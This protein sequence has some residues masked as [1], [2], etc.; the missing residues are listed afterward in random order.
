MDR[1]RVPFSMTLWQYIHRNVWLPLLDVLFPP[2]CLHC[3]TSLYAAPGLPLCASC[4]NELTLIAPQWVHKH[5]LE[6][7]ENRAIDQ[8]V[9]ALEFNAV[10]QTLIHHLKY[11]SMGNIGTALGEWIAPIVQEGLPNLSSAGIVPIPLHPKR[12]KERGYNQSEKIATGLSSQM[13]IPLIPGALKRHRYT[14]SQT[15]LNRVERQQN[16]QDAFEVP[17]AG[18]LPPTV[19]LVD[20][21]VT[22]GATLNACAKVLKEAGVVQV[23]G[24]AVATPRDAQFG[25][26]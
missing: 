23:I 21:V 4:Q 24:I 2:V 10:V 22:T 16:V 26:I 3:D 1:G 11:Q 25:A 19:L 7:I 13:H 8:L 18:I 17:N 12:R 14:Q 6:R 20:D 15:K 5:V 9:V